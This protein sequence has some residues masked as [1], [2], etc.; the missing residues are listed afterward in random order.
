MNFRYLLLFLVLGSVVFAETDCNL[1]YT[2]NMTVRVLDAKYRPVEGASVIIRHQ[3]SGS[4]GPAGGTYHTVGPKVTDS[5]GQINAYIQNAEMSESLLDC[6]I[7]INATIGSSSETSSVTA[8]SHPNIVDVVM[9]VYPVLIHVKDQAGAPLE[10]ATITI[11][12][13]IKMADSNGYVKFYSEQGKVNY[14]VSYLSGKQSGI[15]D[16]LGDVDYTTS[17]AFYPITITVVDDNGNPLNATISIFNKTMET[18]PSGEFTEDKTFGEEIEFSATYKGLKKDISMYPA[19]STKE[20]VVFDLNSPKIG[21]ISKEV[22]DEK[23]RLTIPV[24]DE[25][26]YPSGVDPS[27]ISI[28]YRLEQAGTSAAWSKATTY[29]SSKNIFIADFPEFNQSSLVQFRVEVNDKEGNKAT[30]N[31]R[32]TTSTTQP[33]T[34]DTNSQQNQDEEGEFPLLPLVGGI[35]II[36]F[37]LYVFFHFG[38]KGGEKQQV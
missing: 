10:N 5:S 1:S 22:I 26:L 29:V 34:T 20:Q 30:V 21:S 19:T 4:L 2:D 28:T 17:L 25:G 24:T 16:V 27:T 38:K 9:D 15:I 8:N 18:G 36:A 35:I 37:L 14:F 31:G 7:D 32:F 12:G 3:Y 13:Q 6:N 11:D 33:P 23:V